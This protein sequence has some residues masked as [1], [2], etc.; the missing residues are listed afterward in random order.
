MATS[1][2]NG[3]DTKTYRHEKEKENVYFSNKLICTL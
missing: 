3:F 2:I 1:C